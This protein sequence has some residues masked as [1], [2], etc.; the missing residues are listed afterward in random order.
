MNGNWYYC[1]DIDVKL[2]PTFFKILSEGFFTGRYNETLEI[3]Y[4]ERG[5]LSSDGDKWVDKH[6]GYYISDINF[7]TSEGYDKSGYKIKTSEVMEET[8][9]DKLKNLNIKETTNVEYTTVLAK[10]LSKMISSFDKKLYISTKDHHN[11]VL[12][13]TIESINTN[14][15]DENE[16]RELY[17][18]QVKKGKVA[19]SI[20]RKS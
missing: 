20:Y 7:D 5:V 3:I 9:S 18:I 15:P 2:L 19:V 14:V 1:I 13:I 16:Y 10:I 8:M 12:K 17:A 11:F 6:S 4:K